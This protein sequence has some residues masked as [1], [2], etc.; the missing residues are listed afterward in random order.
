MFFQ[1]LK[2]NISDNHEALTFHQYTHLCQTRQT[3]T[4]VFHHII[5]ILVFGVVKHNTCQIKWILSV[6]TSPHFKLPYFV[7]FTVYRFRD[8]IL[9]DST[10]CRGGENRELLFQW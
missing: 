3:K 5:T 9:R 10:K 7:L 8:N 2:N 6:I 4:L 1:Y